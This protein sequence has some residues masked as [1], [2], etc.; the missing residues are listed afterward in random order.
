MTNSQLEAILALTDNSE[1]VKLLS[2]TSFAVPLW[3]DLLPQYDPM[4]H[5]IWD[6][7]AYPV[8][9]TETGQDDFKRTPLALQKLAVSRIAQAMF[10]AS[11]ERKYSYLTGSDTEKKASS[12]IE[13]VYRINNNIDSTNIERAKRVNAC[14]EVVTVWKVYDKPGTIEGEQVTKK[15]THSIY[16]EMDGYKIYANNDEN[17]E[18]LVVSIAYKDKANVAYFDTYINGVAPEFRRYV[19]RGG[20]KL[21]ETSTPSPLKLEVFP[22]VHT[23]LPEPVW[24]GKAGTA[25]VEQLEEMESFQGLY[26]KRNSL[27][28]FTLDYG[29]ITNNSPNEVTEKSTDSRHIILVGKGGVMQDVTWPGAKE[30]I[31]DRYGRIRNSFFEQV[32][33]PDISF[34]NMINSNT[35]AE[36]KELLFSDAKAKARDLGGEWEKMFYDELEIIKKF[37]AVL[38]PKYTNEFNSISIR[39]EIQPYSVNSKKELAEYISLAG[40][41]MSLSTRVELLREVDDYA[42]EV[43]A[44]EDELSVNNQI[45]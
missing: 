29:E 33:M 13:Q 11:T 40:G 28:T 27:P 34:A 23:W 31:A 43:K 17:G 14:C 44:I 41:S 25:L 5:K 39:S 26:I 16:S 7:V 37:L 9:L 12:I 8:K 19:N 6:T 21:D 30:A 15:L 36:N 35:S 18:L 4:L 1:I 24:G 10:S 32:Q 20:W 3:T 2:V 42:S 22:V 38:L 45:I